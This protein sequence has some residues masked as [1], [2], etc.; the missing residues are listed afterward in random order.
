MTVR[1]LDKMFSPR[2]VAF[3]G[4]SDQTGSVGKT[5][6]HNLFSTGFD[7]PVWPVNPHHSEISGHKCYPDVASLPEAPDLAII[8][9]PPQK[10]PTLIGQLGKKGTRA[11][12]VIT[13]GVDEKA[14]LK[15]AK[16]YC[17]RIVGPNCFGLMLP[18][19]DI[20]GSFAHLNPH[21]GDLA[22]LSQS[23]AI[24]SAV[25]DWAADRNIGFSHIVSLG[26]MADVDVG[27]VLD[28][29]AMDT[30]SRAILMYLEQVTDARK[31]MSS[32][33]AAARIKPVIVIK[34]GRHT[35]GAKAAASH[36]GA[37]A[38]MDI[39][40]D[41]A[42]R[43]AGLLRVTEMEELFDAAE[44]LSRIRP[45]EGRKLV[46]VTNG[47]GAGVM[48][49]DRL[50][51]HGGT[52]ASLS[53]KTMEK[54]DKVL[55]AAWSGD[56]PV[57]IIGDAGPERYAAALQAVLE[58]KDSDA[59]LII[60]CPTAL[61]SS[62]DAAQ[63]VIDTLKKRRER[64]VLAAWLGGDAARKGRS[65]LA[66]EDIPVYE[67]PE[68]AI[69]GLSYLTGHARLQE[70]LMRTPPAFPDDHETEPQIAKN[71]IRD[72][73][74]AGRSLLTETESK[75][76]LAAYGIPI[77]P[78]HKART[79]QDVHHH[80]ERL[81]KNVRKIVVK[82]LSEEITHK[83][84]AGGVALNLSSPEAAQ[85]AAQDMLDHLGK[86]IEGFAVQPMI[87]QSGAHEL[88]FG[89]A[90]D[91]TF[92]PVILFGAGGTGAEIIDDKAIGL[93]PLDMHLARDLMERTR[94]FRLLKG[95]RN[96]PAADLDAIAMILVRLSRMIADCPEIHE[97]DINPLLADKNGV[98]ALDARIVV[99]DTVQSRLSIRPYPHQWEKKETL[100]DGKTI[101]IRPVRPED[102]R[103]Y[104]LFIKKL[105]PDDIRLRLFEPLQRLSHQFVARLTQIDYARA[106]AFVAIDPD[107]DEMLGV[108][109][110]SADSDYQKAEFAIITRSD[111]KGKGIGWALMRR[112]TDY[113][114][115]ENIGE[116]WGQVLA[117][118]TSMLKMC[119]EFGF[120][121]RPDP[122]DI[123]LVEATLKLEARKAA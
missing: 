2:S 20:N 70:E 108:S 113:A 94:I 26:N 62:T 78:T 115:A 21:K 27:D 28:Y 36:T 123:T 71:I 66:K 54:L 18:P 6:I 72:I 46:I 110:L 67:T 39:V 64:T 75:D 95:Y 101:L 16:P 93:P 73:L 112:L 111:M 34:A 88:I 4:A 107:T 37:M 23:G 69:R 116:L 13:A 117:D 65:L 89:I 38:G 76:I 25:I 59:V 12:V 68:D 106:M 103:Y 56:N 58:D 15:A 83:S 7:G 98:I 80:A 17:L 9:T 50:I 51:D 5:V 84:D 3:F 114:A 91:K 29:L 86:K 42:F 53:P 41:A 74:K 55:P 49:V 40:Y 24:I 122:S 57:D 109:R 77:V 22:F 100:P 102:E 43:R 31:F 120:T 8:A 35:E 47:G 105:D 44:V 32:A 118:N 14:M 81:L 85:K 121:T 99:K 48:A 11:V 104:E 19:L 52:L 1:N 45:V 61:A 96:R 63:A 119:R 97:L 92:G 79:P 30:K 10:I 60:N 87:E 90:D 33:R 82:I